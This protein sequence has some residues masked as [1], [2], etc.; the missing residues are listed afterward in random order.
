VSFTYTAGSTANRDRVRL[1]IG[2]TDSA[3]AAQQRL[4]D[5]EINDL[6]AISGGFW[7]GAAAAAGALA[8]KFARLA[9]SKQMGQASLVWQRFQQL[10]QLATDLSAKASYTAVPFASG[11]SRALRDTNEQDTDIIP[12]A[13]KEGMLDNPSTLDS[14]TTST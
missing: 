14:N 2:D 6:I 8:A 11:Y 13:F 10:R 3:A 4:E 5:E 9:T 1:L 12:P 7:N